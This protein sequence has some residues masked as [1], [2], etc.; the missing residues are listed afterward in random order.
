[1]ARSRVPLVPW[2][3]EQLALQAVATERLRASVARVRAASPAEYGAAVV[4]AR[5]A[6]KAHRR[7]FRRQSP[8][9]RLIELWRAEGRRDS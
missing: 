6:L 5:D 2:T 9:K 4:E 1:M 3:A 8:A 7:A